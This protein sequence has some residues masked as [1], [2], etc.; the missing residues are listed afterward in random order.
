VFLS[1]TGEFRAWP[2][3]R[4]FVAAARDA[5]QRAGHAATDMAFF[6]ARSEQPAEVC[7]AK[8]AEADV[9]V[10]IL[11]FR[12]GSPV[13]DDPRVSYTELLQHDVAHCE[14]AVG[15]EGRAIG[16]SAPG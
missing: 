16:G 3:G 14:R 1:H 9:Y 7:R 8:V 13:R 5:V 4:S 2:P 6:G 10:G 15:K 11:G 12:Y